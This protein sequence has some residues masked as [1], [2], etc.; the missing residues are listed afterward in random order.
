MAADVLRVGGVRDGEAPVMKSDA[1]VLASVGQAKAGCAV[2]DVRILAVMV[3]VVE[4]PDTIAGLRDRLAIGQ[5]TAS[6]WVNRAAAA[7]VVVVGVGGDPDDRRRTVVSITPQG[8]RRLDRYVAMRRTAD[9]IN[10][11]RNDNGVV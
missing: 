1:R 5:S 3:A 2:H 10:A 4:A 9:A 8:R 6:E 11:R 7:G